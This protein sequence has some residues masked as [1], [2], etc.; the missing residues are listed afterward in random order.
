MITNNFF[1][2]QNFT[3]FMNST[4]KN[5]G[6]KLHK[7]Q[8][9]LIKKSL[10]DINNQKDS[11]T[12]VLNLSRGKK[13]EKLAFLTSFLFFTIFTS[14]P[15]FSRI[16]NILPVF[17]SK[18]SKKNLYQKLSQVPVFAVTN[19]TGQPYLA[20][21]S[22]G[23]Q[24]GLIFFSQDDALS[25]LKSMQKSHQALEARIYIMGLDKAY[26]M[27]LSNASP[28]NSR[29]PRSGIKNGFQVLSRPKGSK[30]MLIVLK[31]T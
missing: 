24:I 7:K 1:F 13:L 23:E 9:K 15:G 16:D 3:E 8:T 22:N 21:N 30:K 6:I 18:F 29:K 26:R 25:M 27:V 4:I 19:A 31:K 2:K 5:S 12:N 10:F 20:N 14:Y 28:S 17:S 11:N